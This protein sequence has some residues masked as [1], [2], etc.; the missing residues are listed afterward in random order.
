MD[1][2][3]RRLRNTTQQA[4]EEGRAGGL[5]HHGVVVT[6]RKGQN[7]RGGTEAG[8]VP[9]AHRALDEVIAQGL[10]VDQHEGVEWPVKTQ[11]DQEWVQHRDGQGEDERSVV[12][13][14][15]QTS[16]N[17]VT[18]PHT[19]RANDES[20]QWDEENQGQEGNE[21]HVHCGRNDLLETLVEE[22]GDGSHD[23]RDEDV[24][25]IVLQLHRQTKDI[26]GALLSR[27][28]LIGHALDGRIIGEAS[29]LRGEH[30]EHDRRGDPG[31]DAQL[32][33][34]VIG[35]HDGQEEEDGAP[36]GVNKNPRCGLILS[37]EVND[38]QG[39]QHSGEGND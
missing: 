11:R 37:A 24:S 19:E 36:H 2:V 17:A 9:R 21:D 25:A 4:S 3:E 16:T 38:A 7:T 18:S 20:S 31:I 8:E 35:H 22:G 1:T 27:Q 30:R 29:E 39:V 6:D 34:G 10:D 33:A 15:G 5:T 26:D 32:L 13:E 12:I 28:R 23:E 14:P